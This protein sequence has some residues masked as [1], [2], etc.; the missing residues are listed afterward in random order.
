MVLKQGG[1]LVTKWEEEMIIKY[2]H[3]CSD[4]MIEQQ[5]GDVVITL[6]ETDS[7]FS[8]LVGGSGGGKKVTKKI[9]SPT[10][11]TAAAL[12]NKGFKI[13]KKEELL[14]F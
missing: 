11:A 9:S 7:W 4:A 3:M 12:I 8:G 5:S 14:N 6:N 10:A 13:H 1:I 2:K